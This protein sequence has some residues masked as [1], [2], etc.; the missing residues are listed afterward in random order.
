MTDEEL[1]M[2]AAEQV[3][4]ARSLNGLDKDALGIALVIADATWLEEYVRD[5]GLKCLASLRTATKP[6]GKL[7]TE[8]A[9]Q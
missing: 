5:G 4:R 8:F 2:W 9:R 3:I 1:R 7:R 6:D